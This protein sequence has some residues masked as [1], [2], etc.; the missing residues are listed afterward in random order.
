MDH[1]A[2]DKSPSPDPIPIKQEQLSRE[3]TPFHYPSVAPQSRHNTPTAA[4]PTSPIID[5]DTPACSQESTNTVST[6]PVPDSPI[7]PKLEDD[8]LIQSPLIQDSPSNNP[9]SS[10]R[11]KRKSRRGGKATVIESTSL[12]I[13][14]V[15][16]PPSMTLTEANKHWFDVFHAKQ[17]GQSISTIATEQHHVST[18]SH[19]DEQFNYVK[20][21]LARS[22]SWLIFPLRWALHYAAIY[23]LPFAI[24]LTILALI[25]YLIFPR[26]IFT[27]IP[28]IFTTTTSILAFPARLLVTRTPGVWCN[29]VG[30]G[31]YKS[32]SDGE[33]VV[34]NATF[35]TDLEVRNAFTVIHN[36]NYLNNS[37]NRLVLDSVTASTTM[38]I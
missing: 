28:S 25:T 24:A 8:T 14:E 37:S 3:N 11:K 35:A 36:L 23:L 38:L 13:G 32:N 27:A 21:I 4:P 12:P 31:C 10:R 33:E 17:S 19:I 15:S 18:A 34:R 1:N 29:Y 20:E 30:I 26:Y 7:R 6:A 5:T 2:T 22:I 16:S 9:G